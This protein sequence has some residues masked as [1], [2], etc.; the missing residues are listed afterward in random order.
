MTS[1][2]VARVKSILS[3]L[4]LVALVLIGQG[5]NV[6]VYT[7]GILM[8]LALVIIGF[9]F[10]NIAEDR[11]ARRLVIPLVVTW[12]IVGGIFALSYVLAPLL[13]QIGS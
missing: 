7:F 11:P 10:N 2:V 3:V 8:M 6:T 13:A 9:T 1:T 12:V 4:L 5:L